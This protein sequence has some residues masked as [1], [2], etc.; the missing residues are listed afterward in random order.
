MNP[1]RNSKLYKLEID[2]LVMAMKIS[3]SLKQKLKGFLTG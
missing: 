1:V 2:L 3:L